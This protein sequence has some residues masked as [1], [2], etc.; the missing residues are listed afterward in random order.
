MTFLWIAWGIGG[1]WALLVCLL[2]IYVVALP[3]A[4]RYGT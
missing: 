3:V 1:A 2:L 4:L